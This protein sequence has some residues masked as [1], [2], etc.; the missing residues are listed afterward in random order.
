MG[1]SIFFLSVNRVF[2]LYA[3]ERKFSTTTILAIAIPIAVSV[4]LF[5]IAYCYIVRKPKKKYD[6]VTDETGN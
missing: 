2:C 6:A 1:M 5:V 3:G 4:L